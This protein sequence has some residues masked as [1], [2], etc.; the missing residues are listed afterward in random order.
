[1]N[2][3]MKVAIINNVYSKL[4]SN[5]QNNS[6]YKREYNHVYTYLKHVFNIS[7]N[8]EW[9]LKYIPEPF[10]QFDQRKVNEEYPTDEYLELYETTLKYINSKRDWFFDIYKER[11]LLNQITG[12]SDGN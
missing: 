5:I 1:M 9:L 4:Y 6:E 12:K 2:V 11:M 3:I 10:I 8:S 7:T